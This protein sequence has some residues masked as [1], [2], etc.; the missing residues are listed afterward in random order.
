LNEQLKVLSGEIE[1]NPKSLKEFNL[2]NDEELTARNTIILHIEA[3]LKA[4]NAL[5]GLKTETP[6]ETIKRLQV[7]SNK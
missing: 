2:L 1:K 5:A 3:Q 7:N 6:E 4:I